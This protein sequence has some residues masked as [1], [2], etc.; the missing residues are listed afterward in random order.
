M[1]NEN[2]GQLPS[3]SNNCLRLFVT[4]RVEL[5]LDKF[6]VQIPLDSTSHFQNY[7]SWTERSE[8]AVI[9]Q[10]R[11][12]SRRRIFRI[13]CS[14][15]CADTSMITSLRQYVTWRPGDDLDITPLPGCDPYRSSGWTV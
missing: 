11:A 4:N 14:N 10:V 15:S 9:R 12:E 1:S 13:C 8:D 7:R 5:H 2:P 6:A 3:L